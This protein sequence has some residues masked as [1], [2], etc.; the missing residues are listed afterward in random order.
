MLLGLL[1]CS[2]LSHVSKHVER[3]HCLLRLQS[4]RSNL[5]KS[6]PVKVTSFVAEV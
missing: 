6:S 4:K 3:R 5:A 1:L 2:L